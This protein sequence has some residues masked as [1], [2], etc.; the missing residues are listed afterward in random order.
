[1]AVQST[2]SKLLTDQKLSSLLK[3]KKRQ[4]SKLS[5]SNLYT[6][7]KG[8]GEIIKPAALSVHT[9]RNNKTNLLFIKFC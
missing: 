9:H 7:S 1:M 2:G 6:C 8:G 5:H 4:Y 3:K